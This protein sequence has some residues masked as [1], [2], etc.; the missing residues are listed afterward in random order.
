[1]G[2]GRRRP[3]YQEIAANLRNDILSGKL[4]PGDLLPSTDEF[5]IAWK[6]SYF[7]VHTA[8]KTLV[9]EGWV[10][11]IHGRGTYVAQPEKR[12][13]HAGIYHSLDIWSDEEASFQRQLNECLVEKF[14]QMGKTTQIIIDSRPE[15]N[16]DDMFPPLALAIFQRQIQCV[17]SPNVN[18]KS[19]PLFS[20]LSIPTAFMTDQPRHPGVNFDA[21]DFIRGAVRNLAEQGCRSIGYITNVPVIDGNFSM[22]VREIKAAGLQTRPEWMIQPPKFQFCVME[23]GFHAFRQLWKLPARPQGLII[24]PDISARGVILAVLQAG[25]RVPEQMKFVI[26]RNAHIP[27][28]C[29]FPATWAICDENAAAD[30]LIASIEKQ[31]GGQRPSGVLIPYTFEHD[32]AARWCD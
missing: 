22:F 8:L 11:R 17:I 15:D 27:L 18:S 12:F 13:L 6:S 24:Y 3:A 31:F 7:T 32:A 4:A 21:T 20:K 26:H 5:A 1:M 30:G 16:Q 29:P 19:L 25:V 9:K 2:K 10:E 28:L 14:R 23:F